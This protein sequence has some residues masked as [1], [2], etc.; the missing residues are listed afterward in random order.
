MGLYICP[1]A[2]SGDDGYVGVFSPTYPPLGT[3]GSYN[4]TV[5]NVEVYR[6]YEPTFTGTEYF[7]YNGLLRFDTSA[8]P[9]AEALLSAYLEGYVESAQ[10]TNNRNFMAEYVSS[11]GSSFAADYTTTPSGTAHAGTALSALATPGLYQFALQNLTS[12]N[13]TGITSLRL[14]VDGGTPT[15]WNSTVIAAYDNTSSRQVP[16]LVITTGLAAQ[17]RA[18]SATGTPPPGATSIA[19]TASAGTT[20]GDKLLCG[21]LYRGG[22]G[23]TITPP[24]GWTLVTNGRVDST[25]NVGLAIYEKTAGAGETGPYSFGTGANRAIAAAVV[26]AYHADG[27]PEMHQASGQANASSA[28]VT[29]PTVSPS[30]AASLLVSFFGID[31]LSTFTPPGAMTERIETIGLIPSGAGAAVKTLYVANTEADGWNTLQD[32]G[33]APTAAFMTTN[34]QGWIIGTTALGNSS[35]YAKDVERLAS[36]FT[37]NTTTP[38]PPSALDQTLKD[39]LRTPTPLAGRMAATAWSI[40][41]SFRSQ[42]LVAAS[43]RIRLRVWASP[44][45]DG[46]NARELT[47]AVQIGTT[48]TLSTTLTATSTVTW[49]PGVVDL[50]NEYLFFQLAWEITTAGA[51]GSQ[52]AT[53]DVNFYLGSTS[54]IVTPSFTPSVGSSL[55][56]ATQDLVGAGATGTRA[57]TAITAAINIGTSVSLQSPTPPI[58]Q[59]VGVG[60]DDGEGLEWGVTIRNLL[61][62]IGVGYSGPLLPGDYLPGDWI[63]EVPEGE[64]YGL[65]AQAGAG[66]L[67][68][69]PGVGSDELVGT[70]T[71]APG[72]STVS[73]SGVAS[74][75]SVGTLTLAPGLVSVALSGVTSDES[76]GT[77]TAVPGAATLSLAGVASDESVGALTAVA[78]VSTLTLIGVASDEQTGSLV[79]TPS[80]VSVTLTG[81]SSDESVGTLTLAPGGVSVSLTGISSDES[82]GTLTL[83]PGL[84]SVSLAGVASDESVGVLTAVPGVFSVSLVGVA[85]DESVGTLT[86]SSAA[87]VSLIGVASDEQVGALTVSSTATVTLAGVATD[88]Q[89]D[90][91]TPVPGGVNVALSGVA[92]EE[93]VGTLTSAPGAVSVSL[94]GVASDEQVGLLATVP[95]GVTVS[96]VGVVS[97]EE[98]GTLTPAPGDVS[99]TL[100]GLASDEQAGTL[101]VSG[102]GVSTLIG[103]PTDEEVGALALAPAGVSVA[104]VGVA[105]DEQAGILTVSSETTVGLAGVVS[106]EQVGTLTPVPGV[107]AV[108]LVGVATDEQVGVLGASGGGTSA[109]TG[110]ASDEE[111]GTLTPAPGAISVALAGVVS[112]E[113][114]GALTPAPGA[115]TIALSGVASD[116]QAGVLGVSGGGTSTLIGVASDEQ[117]GALTPAPGPQSVV[118][119]GIASDEQAGTLT[120]APSTVSVT[121]LGVVSDESVGALTPLPGTLT[122]VLA[123]AASDESVGTLTA[124]VEGDTFA[125]LIGVTSDELLGILTPIPSSV[126]VGLAGLFTDELVGILLAGAAPWLG[127]PTVTLKIG[128]KTHMTLRVGNKIALVPELTRERVGA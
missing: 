88:E 64:D 28:T 73:L 77:L 95:G 100:T 4:S 41:I 5:A 12:I 75:E 44:N 34:P 11:W 23:V 49:S 3:P 46:T 63:I 92:S 57:A 109:L 70:L 52:S 16:R 122:I 60:F 50:Y 81:V 85:S 27:T 21:I 113:S 17:Y 115:A 72:A 6:S 127:V 91:L 69:L 101:G 7:I 117:A 121:L 103:V 82:V 1:I 14:H 35:Q 94:V 61:Q 118:L 105:T 42:S 32:G 66:N 54:R 124:I 116:E 13:K 29:A 125:A 68:S 37:S 123:G 8:I 26:A 107:V 20:I 56:V 10:N 106:D 48:I 22:T 24:T 33:T 18:V 67:L 71:L 47:S 110:I 30:D 97:D 36:T 79:P 90:T 31:S 43:G 65:T 111:V 126:L 99:V 9:D 39:A 62:R 25:T 128:T 74:D 59:Q 98:T 45:P 19:P 55:E 78:G 93:L 119:A 51:S 2:A 15:G 112:D 114:V 104:L 89:T 38:K 87:T 76:V 96:L 40:G 86:V 53:R 83:V 84:A 58:P 108:A 102:G 120:L 80:G